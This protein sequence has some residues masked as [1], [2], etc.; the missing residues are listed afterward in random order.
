MFSP[1]R[2]KP[3]CS[4]FGLCPGL[5]VDLRCGWD[6]EQSEDVERLG[7]HIR[8]ESPMLVIGSPECAGFSP[9]QGLKRGKPVR[10]SAWFAVAVRAL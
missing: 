1:E 3:I 6:L 4:R 5:A 8:D 2:L 10:R 7:R 9:L